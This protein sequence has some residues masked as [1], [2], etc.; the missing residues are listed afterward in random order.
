MEDKNIEQNNMNLEEENLR[1]TKF[2]L[3]SEWV[4]GY[5]SVALFVTLLLVAILVPM[6]WY[7]VLLLIALSIISF[8]VGMYFCLKIEQTAGYYK[9]KICGHK[10]K[11]KF[12]VSFF[13]Y[14]KSI[15]SRKSR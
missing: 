12:S 6:A 5:T 7:Y 13:F 1:L 10:H 2:L 3:A 15:Q 9:C 4:I 8:V 14:Y 11:P